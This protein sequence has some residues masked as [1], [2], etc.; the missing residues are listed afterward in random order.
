MW[1]NIPN[2]RKVVK[3]CSVN[4]KFITAEKCLFDKK[5]SVLQWRDLAKNFSQP[6]TVHIQRKAI[7][8]LHFFLFFVLFFFFQVQKCKAI[9]ITVKVL[10][11]HSLIIFSLLKNLQI[12]YLISFH[13]DVFRTHALTHTHTLTKIRGKVY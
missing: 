13:C 9:L 7:W 2:L 4:I 1:A 12:K 5:K 3:V 11:M 6:L 8:T 10:W